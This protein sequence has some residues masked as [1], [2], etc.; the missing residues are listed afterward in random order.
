MGPSFRRDDGETVSAAPADAV[1][2]PVE[3][4]ILLFHLLH[5]F[6][7]RVSARL[8]LLFRGEFGVL[9]LIAR[10]AFRL[11]LDESALFDRRSGSRLEREREQ[12]TRARGFRRQRNPGPDMHGAKSIFLFKCAG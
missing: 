5:R 3:R 7:G 6:H 8:G 12:G 4:L 2:L 1:N 10:F 11:G 9:P